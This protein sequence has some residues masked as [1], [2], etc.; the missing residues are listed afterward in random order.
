MINKLLATVIFITTLG[1]ITHFP[2]PITFPQATARSLFTLAVCPQ[3]RHFIY[4]QVETGP[5]TS[6]TAPWATTFRPVPTHADTTY[7]SR[8]GSRLNTCPGENESTFYY[9]LKNRKYT[10]CNRLLVP[11]PLLVLFPFSFSLLQG[12]P[13]LSK[14]TKKIL[15]QAMWIIPGQTKNIPV[16]DYWVK[17]IITYT[18]LFIQNN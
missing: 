9:V 13:A 4:Y 8:R 12:L 10:I 2:R 11:L 17:V 7:H 5:C 18:N 16:S 3:Q 1:H 15:L 6:V 14:H